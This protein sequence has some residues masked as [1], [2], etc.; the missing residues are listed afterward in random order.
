[1]PRINR[2][3]VGAIAAF[4]Q[5][6]RKEREDRYKSDQ[7]FQ[8]RLAL[9][10]LESALREGDVRYDVESGRFETPTMQASTRLGQI[11]PPGPFAP[12]PEGGFI[13]S[14]TGEAEGLPNALVPRT[15]VIHALAPAL[16]AAMTQQRQM[17]PV[18]QQTD[19]GI[20]PRG[21]VPKGARILPMRSKA[22]FDFSQF[23]TPETSADPTIQQR[24]H[25]LRARGM[26]DQQIADFLVEKGIDPSIYGL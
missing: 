24:I 20:Q 25:D 19:T 9:A 22:A 13:G 3:A 7:D 17:Q 10:G 18:Y 11:L 2:G 8:Q 5:E 6:R 21:Q 16:G 15:Q 1:M 14:A 23:E 12:G 26:P 4:A